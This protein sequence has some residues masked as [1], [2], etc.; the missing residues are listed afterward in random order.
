MIEI[1][2]I[3]TVFL[4][5]ALFALGGFLINKIGF[6]KRFCI[7]APVVGGLLFAALATILKTTGTLEIS[8]DTSLQ[9]LFMITFF[10]TIGL[11]ASFKLV[12]LGGK[13]LII[14]WLA[15][16]FLALMQN[17]IGVSLASLM[18]IH[19]LIG[20]MAGAV[21]M[22]GGHG[23]AAAFGQTLEDL[24]ISSAMTIGAAAAT[25]GLVAGGLIGGPIV[26]YLVGKYN[27][28]PDEQEAEEIE[29][30]NKH[31]QITSDSFF[32]QVLL[33]TFCMA[34][35]TYV[36][37]LFSEATGFVLPGYVGAMFVAVL[38][39]NIMDKFK[40][41]AINMK[42]ISLIGDVTLGV[43]LSMALMS[44]KLWEIADLALPLFIIVFAQ[45]FFI[46]VFSTFVLFKLLGKNYDAAVMVAGFAGH[47]LGATPN[48]MA[49]MSAV[50]SRFGPSKKAFLVVPI[51]GAFLI[52][53]FGIPIIIT[54]INLF[55]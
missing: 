5:V 14:Y 32:T 36:G 3:T 15:C 42:S 22:E 33:I 31:E 55:K 4:A 12:K 43:F 53:V 48:A 54:T 46:V 17:V 7:P 27:L 29:Y 34:V 11:G 8:L 45:V 49:N 2:Q 39:R 47:G 9:S 37:T 18:G 16:G 13:L 30:E 35:G 20:M 24:G 25:C 50:V 41:E 1:N 10:T 51:V 19:P 44:I 38:V 6:L 26:K 21:S 40:P 28:T 52:D 23:A